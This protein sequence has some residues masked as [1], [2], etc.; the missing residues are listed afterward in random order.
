MFRSVLISLVT[1]TALC[2]LATSAYAQ[3]VLPDIIGASDKGINILSWTCQYD[4]IKSIAV[5]R[6]SD[7]VYSYATIGY[8]K[9]K[10]KGP[11]AYIDGHPEIGTNWYR[12]Y[13]VFASDLT[14]YSNR[15]K[16]E[17]DSATLL[18]KSVIPPN[19]SLQQYATNIKMETSTISNPDENAPENEREQLIA[20]LSI[21]IPEPD[22]INQFTYIKSQ[23]VFT[24]PFT[25]HV[26]I[27]L[28][29][30]EGVL[31][32]SL[33]FFNIDDVE[34]L[35]I[36]RFSEKQVIIDKRNF[37][38]KGVYKFILIKNREVIEEGHITIY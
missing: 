8:V 6:S 17:I 38:N 34:V 37:R 3:P 4:G 25:G 16:I 26:N 32:Y 23:Y 30:E 29:Q 1:V 14:W 11:Q 19:D 28:P 2:C 36:P 31:L 20:N 12:L 18:S 35:D 24:N 10:K 7:S 13:I 15:I 5:Q 22:E 9:N 33:K 21:E 27:E